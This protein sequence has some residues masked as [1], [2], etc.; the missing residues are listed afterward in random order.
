MDE[1]L[2]YYKLYIQ[3]IEYTNETKVQNAS[4]ILSVLNL[5]FAPF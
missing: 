3:K 2:H 5:N 1:N 4:V